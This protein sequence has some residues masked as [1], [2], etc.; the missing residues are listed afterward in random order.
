MQRI[1]EIFKGIQRECDFLR[2]PPEKLE[3]EKILWTS[4]KRI[5]RVRVNNEIK[6]MMRK[7]T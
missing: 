2:Y 4:I 7:Y 1:A 6:E 3:Y 5:F